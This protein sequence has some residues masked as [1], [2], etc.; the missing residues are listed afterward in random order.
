M[1]FLDYLLQEGKSSKATYIEFLQQYNPTDLSIHL[2]FEGKDDS[3]FY[4]NFINQINVRRFSVFY[5]NSNNK[6]GVYINYNKIDWSFYNKN[7]ILFFVDK[8][9]SDILL[10]SYPSDINIFVT[11]F[12]SIE[13]YVACEQV[14]KSVLIDFLKIT[15]IKMVDKVIN[16]YKLDFEKFYEIMLPITS[17]II[18][19]KFNGQKLTLQNLDNNFGHIF[20]FTNMKIEKSKIFKGHDKLLNFLITICQGVTVINQWQDLI[21]IVKDLKLE[22]MK[23]N[24][25]GKFEIWF[26]VK[27][28]E[29]LIAYLNSRIP[30]GDEKYRLNVSLSSSNAI[31]LLGPRTMMPDDIK[32]FLEYHFNRI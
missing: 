3:S 20:R 2:F 22:P 9:Y 10:I 17:W 6:D 23:K 26:F 14:L 15:N 32:D 1:E 29:E 7:R 5:Y 19:Q 28:I 31:Q 25:R 4:T 24:L 27:F 16:L 21:K 18:L 12:Y 30:K 11:K 8:D 13:N